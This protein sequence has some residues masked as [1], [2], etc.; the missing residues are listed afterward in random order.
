[1]N[2]FFQVGTFTLSAID[3]G[4]Q[5]NERRKWIHFFEN[6]DAIFFCASINNYDSKNDKH[7]VIET[8]NQFESIC[9]TRWFD[10]TCKILF[11]SKIDIFKEKISKIDFSV[12]FPDYTGGLNYENAF[13]FISD[14]F[15]E[16]NAG[17]NELF[18]VHPVMAINTEEMRATFSKIIAFITH[19]ER[20]IL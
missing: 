3:V 20:N 5:Y 1:M 2:F 11:L 10:K 6:V 9:G 8:I 15:R 14:K 7:G 17:K 13:N 16:K 12:C 18:F 19:K 4:D